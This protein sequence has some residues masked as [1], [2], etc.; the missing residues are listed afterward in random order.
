MNRCSRKKRQNATVRQKQLSKKATVKKP[1]A[2]MEFLCVFLKSTV[3]RSRQVFVP[4][5]TI[6]CA[7]GGSHQN[8][9]Q[10]MLLQ[11]IK[12]DLLELAENYRPISLS[13]IVSKAMER[14]VCIRLFSHVSQSITSLQQGIMRSRSCSS[15]LLSVLHSIE[16]ALDK[17]K[18]TDILYL[19]FAKA[20]D[21][22]EMVRCHRST[23]RLVF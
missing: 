19:H 21:T 20:F 14:C 10:L 7:L 12:K 18:Q 6:L 9:S 22:A 2:P 16:E 3:S 13:P 1:L 23:D 17:N 4:Y 8:G 11:F 5:S 15:Q